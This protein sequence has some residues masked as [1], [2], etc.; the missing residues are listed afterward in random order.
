MNKLWQVIAQ[1]EISVKVK[2]KSF[3]VSLA[4]MLV[5]IIGLVV[6]NSVLS[7]RTTTDKVGVIDAATATV[8]EQADAATDKSTKIAST[9]Y[10][11]R[12]SLEKAIKDGDVDAGLVKHDGGYLLIGKD[13]IKPEVAAAVD[14]T[15]N[16]PT[17]TTPLG[18]RLLASDGPDSDKRRVV[19]F[20]L[21]ILFYMVALL[22]GLGIAQSVVEEKESRVV[23]I[24]AAAVPTRAMLWGK[25][26]GNT[27]IAFGQVVL[28]V[29]AA[30]VGLVVTQQTE[31]LGGVGAALG[32]YVV[33]FLL[34]FVAL[35]AM[36][37]AGGAMAG[38]LADVN[39]TTMPL[40]MILLAGYLLGFNGGNTLQTI[41][42]M[43]PVV[44]PLVMPGRI[45][46]GDVP[47]WQILLS[48]LLNAVAAALLVRLGARIYDRNLLQTG[49]RVTFREALR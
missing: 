28:M 5:A 44:S 19:A 14:G 34:G 41:T 11:D 32:W 21:V 29:L 46:M 2:Q 8:V 20:V 33:F 15:L 38:R 6:L 47:L 49:R 10:D 24:L 35:S 23:E 37:S 3:Q 1:R 27:V 25:I 7:G 48:L 13:S 12:A 9:L 26:A 22:F 4:V 43:T 36:W 17:T 39:S 30:V 42:S 31:L 16:P 18:Q 45:A 40:Q